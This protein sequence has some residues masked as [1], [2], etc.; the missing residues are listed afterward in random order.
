MA[1]NRS[2]QAGSRVAQENVAAIKAR[3]REV[4]KK[5]SLFER[6]SDV[7]I[8]AAAGAR[9]IVLHLLWFFVWILINTGLVPAI[10]P[11][12]PF[13]F[14][15]LTMSV[16]LEAIFLALFVLESQNRL[17]KLSDQRA[18]LDLQINLLAER[19][20]TAALQIL[21]DIARHLKVETS[22]SREQLSDMIK[23]TD[24]HEQAL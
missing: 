10:E 5:R 12:D 15:F 11:F 9:S 7:V 14:P 19:E 18:N 16:S 1:A 22:V 17:A 4:Q 24:V 20:M 2:P 6:V 13:P 23:K 3:D 21:S 8:E